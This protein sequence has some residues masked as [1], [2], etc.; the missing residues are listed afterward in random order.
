M[1]K[2]AELGYWK[3]YGL[4]VGTYTVCA[5]VWGLSM[6]AVSVGSFTGTS[7]AYRLGG[8]TGILIDVSLLAFVLAAIP[9]LF[10]KQGE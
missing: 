4:I 3:T 5:V 2:I 1:R 8:L 7:C 9:Q 6:C 10:K